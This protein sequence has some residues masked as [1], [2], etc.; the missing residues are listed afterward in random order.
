MIGKKYKSYLE[1]ALTL[2]Q[3]HDYF[4]VTFRAVWYKGL[5]QQRKARLTGSFL[6][7]TWPLQ[8][9]NSNLIMALSYALSHNKKG[10]FELEIN[11]I[12][13]IYLRKISSQLWLFSSSKDDATLAKRQIL[14]MCLPSFPKNDHNFAK[15]SPMLKT[16]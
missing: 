14:R 4:K 2:K 1:R 13:K 11:L 15:I 6:Q 10:N 16:L 5:L 8:A 9:I 3:S 7:D 12:V